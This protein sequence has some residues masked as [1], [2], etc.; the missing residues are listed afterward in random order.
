MQIIA[1]YYVAGCMSVFS[2]SRYGIRYRRH[3]ENFFLIFAKSGDII[4]DKIG[5]I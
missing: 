2:G 5:D 3:P 1:A 4:I